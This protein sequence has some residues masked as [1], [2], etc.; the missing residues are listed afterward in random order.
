MCISHLL[1][2]AVMKNTGVLFAND[3][4]RDRTKAIVGNFHRLGV[5]NSVVTCYDGRK[6]TSVCS[7]YS[8]FHLTLFLKSWLFMWQLLIY[9]IFFIFV[10][11][12]ERF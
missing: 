7:F 8:R 6:I 3:A 11:G 9:C 10:V 12:A 5:V 4:N 1:T 2:A